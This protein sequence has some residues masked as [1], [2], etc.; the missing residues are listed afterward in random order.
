M[1]QIHIDDVY[2]GLCVP[3]WWDFRNNFLIIEPSKGTNIIEIF[4]KGRRGMCLKM[5]RDNM[6]H[7]FICSKFVPIE[8]WTIDLRNCVIYVWIYVKFQISMTYHDDTS[9]LCVC[10]PRLRLSW[11]H[12]MKTMTN[13][14]IYTYLELKHTYLKES[15]YRLFISFTSRTHMMYTLTPKIRRSNSMLFIE[16]PI[17]FIYLFLCFYEDIEGRQCVTPFS[18]YF[19]HD[20]NRKTYDNKHENNCQSFWTPRATFASL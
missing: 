2:I 8:Y 18:N 15:H 13:N 5:Y 14:A 12:L 16:S 3:I 11:V 17:V 1:W 20:V 19:K 4:N 10:T 9:H 6:S 7:R